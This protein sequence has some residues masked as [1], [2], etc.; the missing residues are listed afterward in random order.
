AGTALFDS[1]AIEDIQFACDRLLPEFQASHGQDGRVSIE[2]SPRFAYDTRGT[3]AEALRLHREVGRQNVMVK[4]P[5]TEAGLP[6]ITGALAEGFRTTGTRIFPPARYEQ[7]M[8]AYLPG[9]EQRLERGKPIE[10]LLSV[11]SF[12]VSRVDTKVDGAI[13]KAVAGLAADDP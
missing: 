6:A 11:A 12:F 9:L 2:V 8:A 7:V 13:D 5:A 4:I 1:L 3:L 10:P